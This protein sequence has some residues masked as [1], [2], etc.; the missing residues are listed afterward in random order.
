MLIVEAPTQ[1]PSAFIDILH[2][3]KRA[4]HPHPFPLPSEEREIEGN[5]LHGG[6][7]TK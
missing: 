2:I 5:I 3:R 7:L 6:I 4:R 1:I